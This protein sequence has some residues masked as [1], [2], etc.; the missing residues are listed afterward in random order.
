MSTT[1][2][3]ENPGANGVPPDVFAEFCA[4][5]LWPGLGTSLAARLAP[6]G[7]TAPALVTAARLEL[8]EGIGSKRA[9]RLAAAFQDA[10][11]S[12]EVAELL[13]ACRVPAVT[14]GPPWRAWAPRRPA[15]YG[16]THGGSCRCRSS[17]PIRPTGSRGRCWPKLPIPRIRGAAGP[18]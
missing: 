6:A 3:Q 11:P 5:G 18:W 16:K 14:P 17:S 4:A 10:R 9:L 15:S 8:V 2:E 1:M 12:Y 13:V 7:I